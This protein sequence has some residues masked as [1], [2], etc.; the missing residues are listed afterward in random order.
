MSKGF[1]GVPGNMQAIMRQAQKMQQEL[2]KAQEESE[3][4]TA[5]GTAGGGMVKVMANGRN[6]LTAV[7]MEKEVV[8]PEDLEMLQDLVLAAANDALKKVQAVVKSRLEEVTGG[9]N[10]PGL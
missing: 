5:E 1:A 6:Q 3:S 4:F 2:K 7:T 9:I 10:I 8:N